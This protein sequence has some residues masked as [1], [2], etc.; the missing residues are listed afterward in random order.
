MNEGYTDDNPKTA[1]G[2]AKVPL[3]LVPPVALHQLAC[4]FA[5]G[6]KKYGPYNWREKRISS[7]VY[8]AAALRHIT[9]WWDGEDV[10]ED[11]GQHHLAHA[12]AC[13]TLVLD[14]QE[15]GMLNDNRPPKGPVPKLQK[16][17]VNGDI[18]RDTGGSDRGAGQRSVESVFARDGTAYTTEDGLRQVFN[19]DAR[20]R[21][22]ASGIEISNSCGILGC[23]I[24][25]KHIHPGLGYVGEDK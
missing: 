3:D 6:A 24:C 16:E 12:M 2:S 8:Y 21:R 7:S 9:A 19:V 5:D 23:P 11:S 10:A 25:I 13:L 15:L 18:K 1:V 20:S 4:V 14:S 17:Y 22:G